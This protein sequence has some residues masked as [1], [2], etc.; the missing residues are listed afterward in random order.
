M[1]YR[2]IVSKSK[3][4]MQQETP[5]NIEFYEFF[6]AV[7]MTMNKRGSRR[8]PQVNI[9]LGFQATKNLL[10]TSPNLWSFY[11]VINLDEN[12]NWTFST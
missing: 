11:I 3:K 6:N 7:T 4:K 8:P 9:V 10:I 1:N 2:K 5:K 12:K